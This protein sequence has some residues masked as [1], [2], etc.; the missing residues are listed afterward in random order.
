VL[1]RITASVTGICRREIPTGQLAQRAKKY[2][3]YL[4]DLTMGRPPSGRC[5]CIPAGKMNRANLR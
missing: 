4:Y 2:F 5:A 1:F 3:G